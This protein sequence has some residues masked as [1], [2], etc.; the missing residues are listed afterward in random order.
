[1]PFYILTISPFGP[2]ETMIWTGLIMGITP[3]MAAV[4]S[5]FWGRLTSRF[6]AKL[7]FERGFLCNGIIVLIMGFTDN[8]H[9]L[10]LLRI[11]HGLLGGVSTIGLILISGLSPEERLHKDVSLFQNFITVGQLLGPPLGTYAASSLG[12]RGAFICASALIFI[13]LYFCHRNVPDIPLRK[14]EPRQDAPRRRLLLWGWALGLIGTIQITF[15][16]SILPRVLEGFDFRGNAA[17]NLAGTLIM[18]YTGT[19]ILGNY[20][21]SRL[22]SRIG[23]KKVITVVC[24]SAACLQLLLYLPSGVGSF[25]V[26]RMIQTGFIA[27]V[28]PLTI[29]LFAQGAGGGTIGFLNSARFFGNGLG[30]LLATSVLA[31]FNLLTLYIFIAGSTLIAM[32]IFLTSSKNQE[33]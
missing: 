32:W 20:G 18:L 22:S 33:A 23:L 28:F 27:A 2:R 6:R 30:P 26:I 13:S 24:L 14:E 21:F 3:F 7:L 8:L 25:I 17:L 1:M 29:S 15:L 10:L 9:L 12:Y 19:A 4:G 5:F 31:Y 16:P 11:F